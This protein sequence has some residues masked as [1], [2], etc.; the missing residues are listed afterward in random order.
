M[1]YT[2]DPD[3][4][5]TRFQSQII[6]H[7]DLLTI[8]PKLSEAGLL[9]RAEQ[10]ELLNSLTG[11]EEKITSLVVWLGS[12]GNDCVARFISCLRSEGT[13]LGHAELVRAI[14]NELRDGES[15]AP[16]PVAERASQP[17][18]C[19][20]C[21]SVSMTS[22]RDASDVNPRL[23]VTSES[24]QHDCVWCHD[25]LQVGSFSQVLQWI[26][27]LI[28]CKKMGAQATLYP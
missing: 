9:T 22:V 5:R 26:P 11:R 7:L 25:V 20:S 1:S 8:T 13:H 4:L 10:E 19:A 16:Y 17:Q 14:E 28:S 15:A 6:A 24:G 18:S 2:V 12:K 3:V 23:L 21:C 27:Q